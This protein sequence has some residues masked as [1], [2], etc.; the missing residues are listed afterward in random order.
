MDRPPC[1]LEPEPLDMEA[2][3]WFNYTHKAGMGGP[4]PNYSA[5]EGVAIPQ[6]FLTRFAWVQE[7]VA[8]KREQEREAKKGRN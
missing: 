4:E 3:R 8:D 2:L 7:V 6:F 1:L 5:G